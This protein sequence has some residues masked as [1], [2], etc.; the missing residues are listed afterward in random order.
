M[1]LQSF[2]ALAVIL[3]LANPQVRELEAPKTAT[4]YVVD[5]SD[6]VPDEALDALVDAR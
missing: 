4:V 6:S 5:V 2:A 1:E 3:A